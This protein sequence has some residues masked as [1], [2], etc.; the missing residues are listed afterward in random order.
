MTAVVTTKT[1]DR[2]RTRS[3]EALAISETLYEAG[4]KNESRDLAGL[5]NQLHNLAQRLEDKIEQYA[6]KAQED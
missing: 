6:H 2:L 1:V 5:S 3:M 4:F